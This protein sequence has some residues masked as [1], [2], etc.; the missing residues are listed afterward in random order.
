MTPYQ[1]E[2]LG[3][4]LAHDVGGNLVA[5]A[6]VALLTAGLRRARKR[7]QQREDNEVSRTAPD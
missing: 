4:F 7:R 6:L 3:D 2:M 1:W 5:A